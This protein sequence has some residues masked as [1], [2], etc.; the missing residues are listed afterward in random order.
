MAELD[1]DCPS[2]LR[3]KIRGLKG[4][5][6]ATLEDRRGIMTGEAFSK[7]LDDCTLEIRDRGVYVGDAKFQWRQ[8]LIGDRVYAMIGLRRAQ[9]S[10]PYE[11]TIRCVNRSCEQQIDWEVPLEEMVVRELPES[12]RQKLSSGDNRFETEFD[13]KKVVFSLQTGDD[14]SKRFRQLEKIKRA[15]RGEGTLDR[16]SALGRSAEH[17]TLLLSHAMRIREV[18]GIPSDSIVEW[19]GELDLLDMKAL[20]DQMDAAD[21]GVETTLDVECSSCGEVQAVELPFDRT[22]FAPSR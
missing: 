8:A 6:F 12:S 9:S 3:C 2:G 21:C 16:S 13:G 4:K 19:L 14:Q 22:F 15:A 7:L 11:F 10:K 5:D 17:G 18:E 1:L 20:L